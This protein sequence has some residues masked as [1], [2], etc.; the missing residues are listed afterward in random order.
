MKM[1]DEVLCI[2]AMSSGE[3]A[4]FDGWGRKVLSIIGGGGTLEGLLSWVEAYDKEKRREF[5]LA[6][7]PTWEMMQL[8]RPSG[9]PAPDWGDT[10]YTFGGGRG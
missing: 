6:N 9:G 4:A 2:V 7:S 1:R 8:P 3:L 5:F 10:G